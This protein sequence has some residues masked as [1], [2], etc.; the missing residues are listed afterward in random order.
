M[1]RTMTDNVFR[2]VT[3]CIAWVAAIFLLTALVQPDGHPLLRLCGG[4]A[5]FVGAWMLI[6]AALALGTRL[7]APASAASPPKGR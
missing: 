3:V 1:A 4:A 7:V 2:G 5:A 6:D